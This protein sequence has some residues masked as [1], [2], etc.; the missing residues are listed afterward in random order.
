MIG[1]KEID[2]FQKGREWRDGGEKRKEDD[3]RMKTFY[4][5]A[6]IFWDEL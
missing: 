3:K 4:V 2:I 6:S 1:N 5:C